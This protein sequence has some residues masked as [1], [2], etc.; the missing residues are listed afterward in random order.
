M[1]RLLPPAPGAP[2][3]RRPPVAHDRGDVVDRVFWHALGRAPSP[4]SGASPKRRIADPRGRRQPS[5][6]GLADLLWAVTD[7]AGVPVDLLRA[8]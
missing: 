1:D 6:D 4:P 5:A 3:P 8:A 7:E 2:L